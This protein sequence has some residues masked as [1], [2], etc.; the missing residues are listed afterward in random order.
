MVR[1]GAGQ[2]PTQPLAELVV[3]RSGIRSAYSN[4]PLKIMA[5]FAQNMA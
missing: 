5:E 2:P 1:R 4:I 3:N